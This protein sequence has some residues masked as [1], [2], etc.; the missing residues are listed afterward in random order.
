MA[1]A[2]NMR[3]ELRRR[4][5]GGK[6]EKVCTYVAPDQATADAML[7]VEVKARQPGDD[8]ADFIAVPDANQA[9]EPVAAPHVEPDPAH[10]PHGDLGAVPEHHQEAPAAKEHAEHQH[11]GVHG[12]KAKHK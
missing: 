1:Y 7:A 11:P 10:H 3:F 5:P 6:H 9:A 4:L 8:P 12:H 2:G